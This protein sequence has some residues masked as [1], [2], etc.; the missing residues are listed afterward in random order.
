MQTSSLSGH[1]GPLFSHEE[2]F[3]VSN[4]LQYFSCV[5]HEQTF[6]FSYVIPVIVAS[7]LLNIPKFLETKFIWPKNSTTA[8]LSDINGNVTIDGKDKVSTCWEMGSLN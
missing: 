5:I 3:K 8:D 2:N 4:L 7:V 1:H 6:I